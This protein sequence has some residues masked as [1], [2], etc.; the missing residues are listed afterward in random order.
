MS[1]NPYQIFIR[2]LVTEKAT[3]LEGEHK[4]LFEI[5]PQANK[6]EVKKAF[7]KIY[8]IKPLRVN[9]INIGGKKVRYGRT[10]GRTKTRKK[11]IITLKKGEKIDLTSK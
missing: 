10:S 3:L 11:A 8:K 4:Y 7:E 2:P 9:I 5:S 1:D 6:I